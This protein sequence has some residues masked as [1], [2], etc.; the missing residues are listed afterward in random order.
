LKIINK[1]KKIGEELTSLAHIIELLHWDQETKI[2]KNGAIERAN[3]IAYLSELYHK[4]STSDEI[5]KL[6]NEINFIDEDLIDNEK[7]SVVDRAFL[8]RFYREVN[9]ER[10]LPTNLVVQLAK[11]TSLAQ[12]V[13][14]EAR[15]KKDFNIFAPSL[16]KIVDIL[17]EKADK[18]GFK[19]H[20]Y[21][22][23]LDEYEP[24]MNSENVKNIFKPL[25]MGL[26]EILKKIRTSNSIDTQ[27]LS[28]NFSVKKQ[29][30]FG[31]TVLKDM[32]Y[33]NDSGRLDISAHPFTVTL[34]AND[35]RITTRYD[36]ASLFSGLFSD[37][38]EGGHALY[39]LGFSKNI[40][41]NILATATSL[42]IHESQSRMWEN[43]IGRSYKFWEFYYPKLKK[44]FKNELKDVDLYDFYRAVNNVSSSL[45][46]VEADEVT[47]N[48][49]IILRF[50]IEMLLINGDIEV[51]DLPEIWNDKT[52]QY[53]GII[54][55]NDSEGVLQ[56][57]HWASGLIGYFPTY[58]LGN[59]YAAQFY[60]KIKNEINDIEKE[61]SKGK[62][63]EILRW[64]RNNIH[65]FGSMYSAEELCKKVTGET[66]NSKYFLNY[67]DD[68]YK[69]IYK[70]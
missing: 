53:L 50:E 21:D 32:G 26:T 61:I 16:K 46:R 52:E 39:E 37:I 41:G 42:G 51:K 10:K 59:I 24:F 66:L 64:L 2:P 31:R 17:K 22:A 44:L 14:H 56:D 6:F 7:Y 12:A 60:N 67:I 11:E 68:K 28:Q 49:H 40:Q 45:I 43:Q 25:Q 65:S 63:N 23:L 29:D 20:P 19:T 48:L 1:L 34:G 9:R 3:Q 33:F 15:V 62:F 13:W 70:Y 38:H 55:V 47:Y 27:F 54:P 57:V 58:A 69:K 35:V 36:E 18:I 8:K 30:E 4:K 5:K